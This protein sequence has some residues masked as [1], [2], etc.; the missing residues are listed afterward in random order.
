MQIHNQPENFLKLE[1]N[2]HAFNW[3]LYHSV[4]DSPKLFE[5][6]TAT[7]NQLENQLVMHEIQPCNT[8]M[9]LEQRAPSWS[10]HL[11][12]KGM[13]ISTSFLTKPS[14]SN[15]HYLSSQFLIYSLTSPKQKIGWLRLLHN[16]FKI[17]MENLKQCWV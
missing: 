14:T 12:T 7:I 1:R 11:N 15:E 10:R 3:Y 6:P 5:E 13:F 9:Y 16:E 17:A 8:R 2:K 4:W